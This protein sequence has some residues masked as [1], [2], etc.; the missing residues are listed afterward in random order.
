MYPSLFFLAPLANGMELGLGANVYLVFRPV[1]RSTPLP[2]NI[3]FVRLSQPSFCLLAS[4]V[5]F[6]DAFKKPFSGF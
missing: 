4:P 3:F 6:L 5:F 1:P 2:G